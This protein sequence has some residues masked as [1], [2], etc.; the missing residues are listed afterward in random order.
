MNFGHENGIRKSQKKLKIG[1]IIEKKLLRV[2][3]AILERRTHLEVIKALERAKS[4]KERFW[5]SAPKR[6]RKCSLLP[7]TAM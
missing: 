4:L 1:S 5:K 3:K 7:T 6:G 2:Y